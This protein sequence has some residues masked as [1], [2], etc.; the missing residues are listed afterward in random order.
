MAHLLGRI[1]TYVIL[2]TW[3]FICLFPIYWTF[4]TSIKNQV[5]V[6]QGPTYIPFWDFEPNRIGWESILG[7]EDQRAI[8]I[9]NALNSLVIAVASSAVAVALGALAGYGLTRFNYKFAIWRNRDISFWFLSQLILPPAAVVM[10]ILILYRELRLLDT[11]LGLILLYAVVNLPI[12]IWI[13]RDQF[14]SIP[15]ELEHAA[16]VDGASL[17]G[18]FSRV[19]LPIAAPGMVAAFIL[20]FIFAWNEYFFAAVLSSTKAVTLPFLIATQVSS[21]GVKWWAMAAI[22]SA[23]ILPLIVIGVLLERFIVKGLTAGA[24]K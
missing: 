11:H 24:V 5:A 13:M 14:G 22:A 15:V 12:V 3:A 23:A 16:L 10:P 17:F 2:L 8:V 9:R 21:Q 20:A 7:D 1:A 4:S 6:L 18:A 19:V